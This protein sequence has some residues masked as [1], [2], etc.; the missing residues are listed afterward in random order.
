MVVMVRYWFFAGFVMTISAKH[1]GSILNAAATKQPFLQGFRGVLLAAEICVMV[2]AFTF[3]G[4][5]ESLAV[6]SAYT[7]IVA[8]LSG[9]IL[10]ETVGWRRWT[11]IIIGLFGVLVIL[12]PGFG[13]FSTYALIPLIAASMFALY[14]ILTRYAA[15]Q[16]ST[17]TSFFWTGIMGCIVMTVVG[18]FYFENMILSDWMLMGCLCCTGVTGHW[19]LIRC[20]EVA[21]V[22]SVQP[23]TYLQM[24]FGAAIGVLVFEEV[25]TLNIAI[26]AMII[27][28]AGL[29]TLWRAHIST[30]EDG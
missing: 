2:T 25:I 14:S 6:F 19:L 1:T 4:L 26:G 23:F 13:V 7:L 29:F 18:S 27:T 15:R 22:S 11:A 20:Y 21:E 28:A 9:P 17:A 8:G 24:V 3:L 5:V 10:G 30:S 16:D 12:K